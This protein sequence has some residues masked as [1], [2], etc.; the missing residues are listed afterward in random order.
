[1]P[2]PPRSRAAKVVVEVVMLAPVGVVGGALPITAGLRKKCSAVNVL[3][4]LPYRQLV[5]CWLVSMH[6]PRCRFGSHLKI[7]CSLALMA[8]G[9]LDNMDCDGE[10][11]NCSSRLWS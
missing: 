10:K 3:V 5:P 6:S 2:S 11:V 9:S 1:M 8:V 7:P 4:S